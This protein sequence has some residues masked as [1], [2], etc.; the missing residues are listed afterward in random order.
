MLIQ[1]KRCCS[2]TLVREKLGE[3]FQFSRFGGFAGDE[4]KMEEPVLHDSADDSDDGES[5]LHRAKMI[6][7]ALTSSAFAFDHSRRHSVLVQHYEVK[8][9]SSSSSSRSN[10]DDVYDKATNSS[11]RSNNDDVYDKATMW[12]ASEKEVLVLAWKSCTK[13][14]LERTHLSFERCALSLLGMAVTILK[15]RYKNNDEDLNDSD[16]DSDSNN[17]SNTTTAAISSIND[18]DDEGIDQPQN[19]FDVYMAGAVLTFVSSL[20]ILIS[21]SKFTNSVRSLSTRLQLNPLNPISYSAAAA[22]A[23]AVDPRGMKAL[24]YHWESR[25][26]MLFVYATVPLLVLASFIFIAYEKMNV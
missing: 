20:I 16:D 15:L 26:T 2:I 23:I 17:N 12:S 25:G 10:N 24:F 9:N 3:R 5:E 21:E 19:D 18:I 22:A 7:H 14:A 6:N 11:S 13:S 8:G 1:F 4:Q